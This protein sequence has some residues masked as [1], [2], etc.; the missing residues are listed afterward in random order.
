MSKA[1][2][3]VECNISLT[4]EQMYQE[5]ESSKDKLGAERTEEI[6]EVLKERGILQP[7]KEVSQQT[8]K[9]VS[10]QTEVVKKKKSDRSE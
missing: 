9:E 1:V 10:Q 5:L 7:E 2:L 4:P 3:W 8:E 6:R